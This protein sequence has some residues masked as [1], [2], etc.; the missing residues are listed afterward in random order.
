LIIVK[1]AILLHLLSLIRLLLSGKHIYD[2]RIEY[3]KTS[4]I[5]IEPQSDKRMMINLDGEYGGDAPI[6]LTNLK[7]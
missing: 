5:V 2:K 4:K 6:T 3:I 1:T 7:N